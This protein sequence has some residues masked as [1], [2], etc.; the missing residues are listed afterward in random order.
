MNKKT[1]AIKPQQK[2]QGTSHPAPPQPAEDRTATRTVIVRPVVNAISILR[3]LT[4][5]GAPERA[6][7]IAR[8]LSINSSTCFNILQNIGSRGCGGLQSTFKDLFRRTGAGTA[9]R[10]ANDSRSTA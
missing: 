10:A 6:A 4:H 8:H 9:C 3:Y 2:S 7:D 5:T 1:T